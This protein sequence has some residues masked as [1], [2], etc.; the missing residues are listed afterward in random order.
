ML[1][2]HRT[3]E[4]DALVR[5]WRFCYKCAVSVRKGGTP[6]STENE[7]VHSVDGLFLCQQTPGNDA[8]L[9]GRRYQRV[10]VTVTV[11]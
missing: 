11:T 8:A 7:P 4:E 9:R 6:L 3:P 5:E 10:T 1:A 2:S